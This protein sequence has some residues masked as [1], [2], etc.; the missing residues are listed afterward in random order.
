M[1]WKETQN[2]ARTHVLE[3]GEEPLLVLHSVG[4]LDWIR[5]RFRLLEGLHVRVVVLGLVEERD[6]PAEDELDG[7]EVLIPRTIVALWVEEEGLEEFESS[8]SDALRSKLSLFD[9]DLG[10][11]WTNPSAEIVSFKE[12]RATRPSLGKD[13]QTKDPSESSSPKTPVPA[14]LP[15]GAMNSSLRDP[16]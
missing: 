11:V 5:S 1:R 4:C 9:V 12:E 8:F 10:D 7:I 15:S 2:E 14:F 16:I 13:S 3:E 6:R